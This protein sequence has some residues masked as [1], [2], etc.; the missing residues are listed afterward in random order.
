MM[1]RHDYISNVWICKQDPGYNLYTKY[2]ECYIPK[3]VALETC[4][5]GF[6]LGQQKNKCSICS[7]AIYEA[8][9]KTA[10]CGYFGKYNT[11]C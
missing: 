3:Q 6:P 1:L 10:V 5:C 9:V 11:I 7:S 2:E 4:Y 8:V